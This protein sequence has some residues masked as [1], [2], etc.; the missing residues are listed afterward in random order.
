MSDLKLSVKNREKV[1]SKALARS[2]KEGLI[3]AVMYGHGNAPEMFW[4]NAI[5]FGKLFKA[6]GQSSIISLIPENGKEANVIVHD[7]QS[8]PL[9]NRLTHIDFFQVRM[10]EALETHI[11]LEFVGEAP[12]VKEL[13]GVLVRTLEEVMVSCLPKDLPHSLEVDLSSIKTFDDHIKVKDL[14]IPNGVTV[15]IEEETTV[16]LVEAPRTEAEMDALDEKPEGDVTKV[17]G[18]VKEETP[19][20]E[21]EKQA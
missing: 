18:V 13:G 4:V 2:R 20:A 17:E 9:S 5:T 3:P 21:G 12:A 7:V 14:K 8:D 19:A 10:D 15:M 11:P 1:A 16:A 6:A